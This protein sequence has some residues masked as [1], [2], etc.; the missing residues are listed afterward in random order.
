MRFKGLI[1]NGNFVNQL[2]FYVLYNIRLYVDIII[3]AP[4]FT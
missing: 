2:Q 4:I 1:M 3:F